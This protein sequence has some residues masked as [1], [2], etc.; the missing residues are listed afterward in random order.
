VATLP[1]LG[2]SAVNSRESTRAG[3]LL[4]GGSPLRIVYVDREA[5]QIL[6]YPEDPGKVKA[7][8]RLILRKIEDILVHPPDS[9]YASSTAE[10]VSGRRRYLCRAFSVRPG[11]DQAFLGT[12]R[13]INESSA[14]ALLWASLSGSRNLSAEDGPARPEILILLER[15]SFPMDTSIAERFHLTARERETIQFLVLGLTNKEI[16]HQMRISP[17]TVKAFLRAIMIKAG[18][19]TRSGIVGKF[20][21]WCLAQQAQQL[22]RRIAGSRDRSL[23]RAS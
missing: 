20:S 2:L 3:L 16:A 19:S 12:I 11:S 6:A 1:D 8:D 7:L 15:R 17:N 4:L 13:G 18:V 5:I 10:F 22:T 14:L 21:A 23:S 9:E